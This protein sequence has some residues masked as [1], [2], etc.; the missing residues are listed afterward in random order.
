MGTNFNMPR[1]IRV[2]P[3]TFNRVQRKIKLL[4]RQIANLDPND[5]VGLESLTM[6]LHIQ[7][8]H[9]G[10]LLTR[11][12]FCKHPH[13]GKIFGAYH[14]YFRGHTFIDGV[15]TCDNRDW[16]ER[17]RDSEIAFDCTTCRDW[18]MNRLKT[19]IDM[20]F[21]NAQLE[22]DNEDMTVRELYVWL[23]APIFWSVDTYEF[24]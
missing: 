19:I 9:M 1:N 6:D 21:G 15:H 17:Y 13:I 3:R 18:Q 23:S 16:E 11:I 4:K 24:S 12:E 20:G 5:I 7:E 8:G 2:K 10:R 14:F 22:H